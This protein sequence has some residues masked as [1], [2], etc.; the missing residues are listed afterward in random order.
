MTIIEGKTAYPYITDFKKE[1]FRSFVV[2]Q[3][4]EIGKFYLSSYNAIINICKTFNENL[5][6]IANL[7]LEHL[8]WFLLLKKYL[9]ENAQRN[10]NEIYDFIKQCEVRDND[11]L[12][13]KLLPNS[14][15]LPDVW[16]TFF[17]IATLKLLG[18]L[19]EYLLSRSTDN[20]AIFIINFIMSHKKGNSF[21][22]CLNEDCEIDDKTS[23]A[24]TLYFV[25]EIFNLLGIDVRTR[26][27]KIISKISDKKRDPELI[28]K[29]LALKFLD[30]ETEVSEKSIEYLLQHQKENGGFS[31]QKINGRINTTFWLVYTLKNYSWLVD[32]NPVGIYSFI[33]A[34]IREILNEDMG[35]NPIKL[36]ELSKLIILLSII[37]KK[38][39]SEIERVIFKHLEKNGYVDLIRITKTFG[40]THGIEEVISYIN[41]NYKF[42]LKILDNK[43]EFHNFIRNLSSGKEIIAQEIHEQ[44][45]ENNIISIKEIYKRYKNSYNSEPLSLKEDIIPLM[46]EMILKNFF[47]GKIVKKRFGKWYFYLDFLLEKLI[48]SDTNINLG[49]ILDEKEKLKDIRNDIY[50]MIL[51]LKNTSS[52]ITEE[53][54]SYLIINEIDYARERLKFV[55]RNAL[56][57]A[58]FLNENIENSFN[59]DLYYM[60]LQNVLSSEISQWNKLYSVL[61]KRLNETDSYLKK[62]IA[63]KEQLR[64]LHNALEQL[65][66]KIFIY[67]DLIRKKIDEFKKYLK[68]LSKSGYSEDNFNSIIE[69][70]YQ[71]RTNVFDFD[72]KI[73]EI[74]QKITSK[75]DII[76]KKRNKI[77][78]NWLGIKSE[79]TEVFDYYIDGF[80]FYQEKITTII[81]YKIKINQEIEDINKKAQDKMQNGQFQE[82]SSIIKKESNELLKNTSKEINQ[83]QDI[84]K[85]QVNKK[86]S[87]YLLYR[88]LQEFCENAEE[89]IIEKIDLQVQSLKKKVKEERNRAIIENFN[90]FVAEHIFELKTELNELKDSLDQARNKQLKD[91]EKGFNRIN[92]KFEKI[93]EHYKQKLEDCKEKIDNFDDSNVS[94][95][96]WN[97]FSEYLT[98]EIMILKEEYINNIIT[99]KIHDYT[100][101]KKSN[102]VSIMDLKK[103]LNLKCK[104][105]MKRIKDLI[106]ISKLNAELDEREKVIL[107][108]TEEYYK[109][110]ELRNFIEN[111]LL[112]LNQE[113]LGKLLA[114]YDSSIRNRTLNVNMLE[115]QNRI[116]DFNQ[117]ENKMIE[118]FNKK[119]FELKINIESRK[120]YIETKSYFNAMLENNGKAINNIST[121]LKTFIYLQNHIEQEYNDLR[122]NLKAEFKQIIENIEKSQDKSYLQVKEISD[123]KWEKLELELRSLQEKIEN[124]LEISL[125]SINE[126]NKLK[127]ELMEISVENKNLFL[128]EFN[129][130]KEKVDE[131]LTVLKDEVLRDRLIEYINNNKIHISQLLGTLQTKV[132]DD[133]EIKEFRRAYYKIHKRSKNIEN[134]ISSLNKRI[135]NKVKNFK[136]QSSN[137]KI[138]NKFILED[139]KLFL[140]EFEAA[141]TEKVKSLERTIVKAYIEMAIKAVSNQFLTTSFLNEELKIKKQ[142]LQDHIIFLI[143]EGSLKGKYDPRLGI[144]YE[145]S[146]VLSSLNE[147]ELEVIKKMN[148]KL[149]MALTRM[150]NFTSQFGSI[151][152]FF[153][154]IM[155]I[156]YYL[157]VFSGGNPSVFA[158]PIGFFFLIIVYFLFRKRGKE[159]VKF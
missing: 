104:V 79:M 113:V 12:G 94:I 67:A 46:E 55:L 107:V 92:S 156:T 110:K 52:Q 3:R 44:L 50:N 131:K 65:E 41:L 86:Q 114:L 115:L 134:Q 40:L 101:D 78:N 136:K 87:L 19:E 57:D 34:S 15:Q 103:D 26:R 127:I 17:A 154:S 29:L 149:Y 84:V 45:K 135:K 20:N 158:M 35:L 42:K 109:N 43:I 100:Q 70:L 93:N 63:E 47:K 14:N 61:S 76:I 11:K 1:P 150:K 102:L 151:I 16:S 122:S 36:M 119:V 8:F 4:R 106:D 2:L 13:F 88:Y 85:E 60:Q 140:N 116:K 132:E 137:F 111:K 141:L 155:T 75:E 142:N 59:L 71:I 64:D 148:F 69:R 129:D 56:M 18:R 144:Y 118:E 54:E 68:E 120:E 58:D 152:A 124:S 10:S 130:K 72:K 30:L 139:F 126:S 121:C 5:F 25:L 48:V 143:S 112:K 133:I 73:Y 38:F 138:K 51:K 23:R 62:K 37:F 53:I 33:N 128:T 108:F 83:L 81:N 89:E 49:Q 32:F 96:K 91:V 21:I 98:Q 97:N 7:N 117:M 90:N 39:I 123:K 82:A 74:S 27:E 80:N 145:N 95:V 147:E 31:F 99:D 6:S 146:E 66:D 153:A 24:R 125:E 9:G 159:K 22:H 77:I 28:Y 105:L 157:F